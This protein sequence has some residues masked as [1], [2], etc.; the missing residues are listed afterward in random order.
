MS[1][2][3]IEI[4]HNHYN[5]YLDWLFNHNVFLL[6]ESAFMMPGNGE[7]FK[8]IVN[9][10]ELAHSICFKSFIIL[11]NKKLCIFCF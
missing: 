5:S 11:G 10:R 8:I 9:R 7:K 2:H 3:W 4:L 6:R 1:K